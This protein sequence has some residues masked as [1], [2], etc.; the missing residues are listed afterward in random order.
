M[1]AVKRTLQV[2]YVTKNAALTR[3]IY[4]KHLIS[5]PVKEWDKHPLASAAINQSLLARIR[6]GDEDARKAFV[7]WN[8][9]EPE[10][11]NNLDLHSLD[12]LLD[13]KAR[14]SLSQIGVDFAKNA[15]GLGGL[16]FTG[17]D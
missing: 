6:H 8:G 16:L 10:A 7:F 14:D 1:P 5:V 17:A 13:E 2:Q 12:P 9:K 4:R 11:M 3:W 15:L